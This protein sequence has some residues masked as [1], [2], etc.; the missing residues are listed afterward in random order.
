MIEIN[1]YKRKKGKQQADIDRQGGEEAE[2]P[3][4]PLPFGK[5]L[6]F[7]AVMTVPTRRCHSSMQAVAPCRLVL[8]MVL[9]LCVSKGTWMASSFVG[10][11]NIVRGRGPGCAGSDNYKWTVREVIIPNLYDLF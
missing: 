4:V 6:I 5:G 10:T 9:P 3:R 1:K 8:R 2:P 7:K 11:E